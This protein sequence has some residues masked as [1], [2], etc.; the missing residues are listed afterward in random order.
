MKIFLFVRKTF[1]AF[2]SLCH[3]FFLF[4]CDKTWTERII[5]SF[6]SSYSTLLMSVSQV[7]KTYGRVGLRPAC[8]SKSESPLAATKSGVNP[9]R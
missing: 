4:S 6:G 3:S 1:S 2:S 8:K 5:E 7:R 9:T